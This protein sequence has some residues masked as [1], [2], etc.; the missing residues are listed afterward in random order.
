MINILAMIQPLVKE[1]KHFLAQLTKPTEMVR[2]VV[3]VTPS[4]YLLRAQHT[5]NHG[6][7]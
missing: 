2:V 6:L 5:F 7:I 1:K 4:I 3:S